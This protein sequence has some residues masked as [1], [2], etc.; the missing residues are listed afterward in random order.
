MHIES[1]LTLKKHK[2]KPLKTQQMLR[3][4]IISVIKKVGTILIF[5]SIMLEVLKGVS[6][7]HPCELLSTIVATLH[8]Y[9][10][11]LM[12][13]SKKGLLPTTILQ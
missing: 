5:F 8:V 4:I 7:L 11:P 1:W 13:T 12:T 9:N 3:K 10:Y 6:Y 2:V